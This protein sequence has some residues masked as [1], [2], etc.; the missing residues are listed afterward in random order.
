VRTE[1]KVDEES[2]DPRAVRVLGDDRSE[3]Q[4]QIETS[5]AHH[6]RRDHHGREYRCRQQAEQRPA[7]PIHC[8]AT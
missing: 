5:P 1:G 8:V 7:S 6:L 3:E 2:H 4:W